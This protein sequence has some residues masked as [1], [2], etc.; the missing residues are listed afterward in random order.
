MNLPLLYF[1]SVINAYHFGIFHICACRHDNS[2]KNFSL[3]VKVRE[4]SKIIKFIQNQAQ[5]HPAI[6]M[7]SSSLYPWQDTFQDFLAGRDYFY[8]E[9]CLIFSVCSHPRAK[10]P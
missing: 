10:L 9:F 3:Y 1:V 2:S 7:F 6:L 4:V 8:L 5:Q